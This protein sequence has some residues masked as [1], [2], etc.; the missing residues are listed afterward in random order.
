MPSL[1]VIFAA[2]AIAGEMVLL[3]PVM[4]GFGIADPFWQ[5][6]T[7][8]VL[9][10]VSSGLLELTIHHIHPASQDEDDNKKGQATNRENRPRPFGV[11]G[12]VITVFLTA[13]AF[14]LVCVL[15][16]WRAE[17]MIFAAEVVGDEWQNFLSQNPTLT[18][19]CVTLLTIGLPIFAAIAFDWGFDRL[20]LA[21][22]WRKAR[23]ADA[24]YSRKLDAAQKKLEAEQEKRDQQIAILEQQKREWTNTYL[25]K[26]ELGRLLGA[27]QRPL[28]RVIFECLVVAALILAGCVL[29]DP[30]LADYMPS[31]ST[32]I[33]LYGLVTLGLG[34]LYTKHALKAWERPTP[35]QLYNNRAIRWHNEA[36][37]AL[38]GQPLEPVISPSPSAHFGSSISAG[39]DG[40]ISVS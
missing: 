8:T 33:L 20:R 39:S 26:H 36:E 25:E 1:A 5:Y 35:E 22:E 4:D 21:W 37:P 27:H 16:W 34:G 19:V 12:V 13:L 38:A 15:G 17:E 11:L 40:R 32:R 7:A 3:A 2:L 6:F 31:G 9:V 24:R 28:A 14:A 29:L 10:L 18:K 30:I 23:W